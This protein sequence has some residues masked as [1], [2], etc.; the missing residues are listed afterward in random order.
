M[1]GGWIKNWKRNEWSLASGSGDVGRGKCETVGTFE[2]DRY[3]AQ[4]GRTIFHHTSHIDGE[5]LT[6]V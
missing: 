5:C 4:P 1:Y 2:V 6:L 3:R